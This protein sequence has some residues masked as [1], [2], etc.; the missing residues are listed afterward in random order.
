MSGNWGGYG[1]GSYQQGGSG[2]YSS[3]PPQGQVS[4]CHSMKPTDLLISAGLIF[5]C[6]DRLRTRKHCTTC[7]QTTY[8]YTQQG[9]QQQSGQQGYG[10]QQGYQSPQQGYGGSQAR[11]LPASIVLLGV[12][13]GGRH[14]L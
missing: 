9:Q 4:L 8:N 5:I 6:L 2:Q 7:L 10:S 3:T 14:A 11:Q 1:Q 12:S 13:N